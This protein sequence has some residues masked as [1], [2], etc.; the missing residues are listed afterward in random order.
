MGLDFIKSQEANSNLMDEM[1]AKRLE[2]HKK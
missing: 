2:N 1:K